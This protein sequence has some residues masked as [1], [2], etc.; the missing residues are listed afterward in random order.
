MLKKSEL[1]DVLMKHLKEE[2]ELYKHY[3]NQEVEA[4][5]VNDKKKEQICHVLSTNHRAKSDFIEQLIKEL[6]LNE[7]DK[8]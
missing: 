5:V 4:Y 7:E 8:D 6:K 3:L 2:Q 1:R